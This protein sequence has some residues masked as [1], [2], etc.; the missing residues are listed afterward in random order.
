METKRRNRAK[1][2]TPLEGRLSREAQRLR[3]EARQ[4]PDGSARES[5]IRRARQ[6]DEAREMSEALTLHP[7]AS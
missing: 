1:Q 3:S 4:T 7:R 6:M 2:T 5:L